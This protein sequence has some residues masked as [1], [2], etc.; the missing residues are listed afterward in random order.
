MAKKGDFRTPFAMILRVL[1]SPFNLLIAVCVMA[2]FSACRSSSEKPRAANLDEKVVSF[3]HKVHAK[4]AG[5]FRISY[6]KNYKLLEIINP[7]L[8]K[9][10]TLRYALVPR[11]LSNQ[12]EVP[13]AREIPIPIRSM[14]ATSTTHLGIT[15]MLNAN[16]I[17]KGMIGAKYVYSKGIRRQVKQGKIVSFPMGRINKERL[18]MMQPDLIMLS[19][20][21]SSQLDNYRVLMN[22]GI[23]V[24]PNAEWLETTPLGKAEWVKVM[25]ALLNKEKLVNKKFHA[26]AERY[27]ELKKAVKKVDEKPLV[28]NNLPFKG[29]WF[30]SGGNSYFARLLKDAGADYPWFDTEKSGGLRLGF[31]TIYEIGLRADVWLNPGAAKTKEDI[32][33]VDPRLKAFKP[34]KT[35]EIYNR[36]KR[37]RPSGGNDI[38]ESGVVHPEIILAD[39]IKIFH[40]EVLPEH[41]LYYY[42]KV[43]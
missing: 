37:K 32:L 41:E 29:A 7:F 22:S 40:P 13:N 38:W 1:P 34:F 39:L 3:P 15:Q 21:Q 43:E 12:I 14:I 27:Q 25:A 11:K 24:L 28:I 4:Y 33:A 31:E 17:I 9:T 42:Q 26:V 6:H 19:A 10:D 20:G 2:F 35:G 30:V 36:N 23:S 16:D 8:G 5:G 18:L